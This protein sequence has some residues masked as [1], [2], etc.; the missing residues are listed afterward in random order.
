MRRSA[1]LCDCTLLMGSMA[2]ISTLINYSYQENNNFACSANPTAIE[3]VSHVTN[4][5]LRLAIV[6]TSTRYAR[7]LDSSIRVA[8]P[9]GPQATDLY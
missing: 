9:S 3:I 7:C 6:A 5:T 2:L 4:S 8:E 1:A